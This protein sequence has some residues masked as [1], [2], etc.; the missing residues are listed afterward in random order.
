MVIHQIGFWKSSKSE[1]VIKLLHKM[2]QR[3]VSP[4]DSICTIVVDMLCKDI[5]YSLDLLPSKSVKVDIEYSFEISPN[6]QT[7][8]FNLVLILRF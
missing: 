8:A 6:F 2:V 7:L 4:N 1:E 3:N 5:E